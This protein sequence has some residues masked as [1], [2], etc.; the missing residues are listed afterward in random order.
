MKTLSYR[1]FTGVFC[2]F[3]PWRPWGKYRLCTLRHKLTPEF[4]QSELNVI[5]V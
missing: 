1:D 5:N 4:M 3:M 2:L